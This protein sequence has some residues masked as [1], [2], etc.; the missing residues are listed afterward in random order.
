MHFI[1]ERE[2]KRNK[3]KIKMKSSMWY[4]HVVCNGD[5]QYSRMQYKRGSTFNFQTLGYQK[6]MKRKN[7]FIFM[8]TLTLKMSNK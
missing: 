1:C 8:D 6:R 2:K 5:A 4:T 3:I 7:V